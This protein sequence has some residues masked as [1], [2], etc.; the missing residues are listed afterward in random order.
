MRE[1]VGIFKAVWFGWGVCW[2]VLC[3]FCL[4]YASVCGCCGLFVGW[5]RVFEF[6]V[7]LV[8]FV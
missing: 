3:K 4:L 5:L 7:V 1:G 8:F 6:S 2:R